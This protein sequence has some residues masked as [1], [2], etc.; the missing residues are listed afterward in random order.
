MGRLTRW[1]YRHPDAVIT[2]V[3][4]LGGAVF[5]R[6]VG[7]IDSAVGAAFIMGLLTFLISNFGPHD[8]ADGPHQ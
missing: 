8:A 2:G 3:G 7:G 5:G 4:A 1:S 6:S